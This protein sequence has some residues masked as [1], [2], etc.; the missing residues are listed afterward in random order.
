MT[1][2]PT[3]IRGPDE[4]VH[5]AGTWNFRTIAPGGCMAEQKVDGWRAACILD[6]SGRPVLMTRNG[7]PI[8][9]A[10]HILHRLALIEKA[11]GCP[12]MFDGEFQVG[13]TLSA[14]KAWCER[15]WKAGGE[16]GVYYLFDA[17]PL[18]E[19]ASGGTDTPLYRRKDLLARAIEA[20]D[21]DGVSW[22]WR[23]RSYGRDDPHCVRLLPDE[24]V[25]D[26]P[27]AMA[28]ANRMW[29]QG[30]EGAMLKDAEAGYKRKRTK[31][32]L[33]VKSPA[34]VAR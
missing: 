21:A 6:R 4:I 14:T 12:L 10:G 34:Y 32:W 19:W 17:V 20:V 5:L 2:H 8:E 29:A 9:G 18:D 27:E 24:W 13:G 22:E 3:L 1:P 11:Y 28:F 7:V 15:G 26:A 30:L 16:A 31:A 33:K 23:E 25:S